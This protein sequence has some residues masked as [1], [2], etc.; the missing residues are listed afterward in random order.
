MCLRSLGRL[1]AFTASI[2]LVGLALSAVAKIWVPLSWWVIF[3][4]CVSI[5]ASLSLVFFLWR[6]HHQSIRSLGLGS[7]RSIGKRQL[8]QGVLLGCGT[9]ALMASLYLGSGICHIGIHPDTTRVWLTLIAFI[10][11]AGL[12]GL[13]EE[14]IFRGY[15]LQQLLAC[16]RWL[17]ITGSSAAY[18]VVHLRAVPV[19]P[20]SGFDLIG[21]FLLGVVL[22]IGTLKTKPLYLAIGLHASLAYWARMNKLLVTFPEPALQWLV[23]TNRLVNGLIAWVV[24]LGLGWFLSRQRRVA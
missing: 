22:A 19:W 23:G 8:I 13:L 17:A 16:S 5:A 11:A 4:R 9:I 2:I 20:Q 7:W 12:I 10:P 14:L 18:A 3:R 6:V 21:L 15:I 24:L 1:L